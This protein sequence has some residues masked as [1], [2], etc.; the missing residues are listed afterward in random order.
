MQRHEPNM[1]SNN[2]APIPSAPPSYNTQNN[3]INIISQSI[4][5]DN[6][7]DEFEICKDYLEK[8]TILSDF[9]IVFLVDDSGSMKT[10][11]QINNKLITRWSLLQNMINISIRLSSIIN[12][13]GIDLF[14]LNNNCQ[15]L[16]CP[17]R[18]P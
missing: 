9:D 16:K 1:E 6:F 14:F 8:V 17:I 13:N 4:L 3:N 5:L 10:P 2:W 11:I 12:R 18:S 15:S 7:F